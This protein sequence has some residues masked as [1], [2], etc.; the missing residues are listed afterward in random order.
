MANVNGWRSTGTADVMVFRPTMDEFANF[1]KY[2]EYMENCG[3]HLK[4]GIAKV[5]II[6]LKYLYNSGNTT[7][8]MASKTKSYW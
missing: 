5:S 1:S 8:R 7:T 3:A 6:E 4:C 2:V